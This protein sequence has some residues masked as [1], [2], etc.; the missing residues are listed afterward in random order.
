MFGA[1][2]NYFKRHQD[3]DY[4]IYKLIKKEEKRKRKIERFVFEAL[5][6]SKKWSVECV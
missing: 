1:Y 4:K 5:L 2:H 3:L 6:P